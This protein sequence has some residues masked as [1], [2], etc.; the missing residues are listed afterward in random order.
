MATPHIAGVVALMFE[1]APSMTMS[2]LEEDLDVEGNPVLHDPT[3]FSSPQE[4]ERY[5]HEAEAILKLTA[6]Y[7]EGGENLASNFS[8]GLVVQS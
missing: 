6:D 1:V 3:G 8:N 7:M 5:I 2:S 4:A